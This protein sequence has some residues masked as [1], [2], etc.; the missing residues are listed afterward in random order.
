[1]KVICICDNIARISI[2]KSYDV[3]AVNKIR[4]TYLI[5]NDDGHKSWYGKNVII[6]IE[7]WREKQLNELGIV[8]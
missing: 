7:E 3:L 6:P 4:D 5:I 1:M 8:V 2:G